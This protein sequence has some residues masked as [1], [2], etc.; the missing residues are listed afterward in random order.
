EKVLA[1][2]PSLFQPALLTK[3]AIQPA[4]LQYHGPA[5]EKAPYIGDD[6]FVPHLMNILTM[7]E[8]EVTLR[9]LPLI[10]SVEK[11]RNVVSAETRRII[12]E[13][14]DT[15]NSAAASIAGCLKTGLGAAE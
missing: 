14:I 7:A 6:V 1:F 9:F 11:N 4:A 8:I 5:K 2:H 13:A 12:S 3:A 15:D 10:D